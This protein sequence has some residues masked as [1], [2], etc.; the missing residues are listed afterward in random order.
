MPLHRR[1]LHHALRS[2]ALREVMARAA[3][4]PTSLIASVNLPA[5]MRRT[6]TGS[7]CEAYAHPVAG[8][9]DNWFQEGTDVALRVAFDND[10]YI[11]LHVTALAQ[12]ESPAN[13]QGQ[14]LCPPLH[15]RFG[16]PPTQHSDLFKC[17][18]PVR[19]DSLPC[20]RSPPTSDTRTSPDSAV[21]RPWLEI[22][23]Y[24]PPLQPALPPQSSDTPRYL[25]S[26]IPQRVVSPASVPTAVVH[27]VRSN[28]SSRP[29]RS[30]SPLR[31]V[32][33]WVAAD[34]AAVRLFMRAATD[35]RQPVLLP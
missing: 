21:V 28:D 22:T 5:V 12:R 18:S 20:R 35:P 11:R 30:A 23:P 9:A 1:L 17:T 27:A 15:T 13:Q 4:W 3:T 8:T 6:S 25:T 19:G 26:S 29:H 14:L 31:R 34:E 2:T 33:I 16:R 32:P 7:L 24:P 10:G